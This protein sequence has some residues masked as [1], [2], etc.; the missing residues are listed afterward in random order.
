MNLVYMH[1]I[2]LDTSYKVKVT[3]TES[4]IQIRVSVVD[5]KYV[6]CYSSIVALYIRDWCII[7]HYVQT[8]SV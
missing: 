6:T 7:T 4:E 3:E 8:I 5:F 2:G 1:T